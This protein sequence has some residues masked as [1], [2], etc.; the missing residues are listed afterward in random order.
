MVWSKTYAHRC[1]QVNYL[2]A[3]YNIALKTKS[4]AQICHSFGNSISPHAATTFHFKMDKYF[5]IILGFHDWY[6]FEKSPLFAF[7]FS[8][9]AVE[10]NNNCLPKASDCWDSRYVFKIIQYDVIELYFPGNSWW[11]IAD[12]LAVMKNEYCQI[13]NDI[14]AFGS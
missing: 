5:S 14:N 9:S 13:D 1:E 3:K 2:D 8:R 12:L 11:T 10:W 7:L 4:L 6:G